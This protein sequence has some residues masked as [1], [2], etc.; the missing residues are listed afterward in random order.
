VTFVIAAAALP[1]FF[2]VFAYPKPSGPYGIGTAAYKLTHGDISAV[3][4]RSDAVPVRRCDSGRAQ[5]ESDDRRGNAQLSSV[6]P[7][8]QAFRAAREGAR[9]RRRLPERA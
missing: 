2:P 9:D 5:C 7:K 8:V 1:T 6:G 4:R 3:G